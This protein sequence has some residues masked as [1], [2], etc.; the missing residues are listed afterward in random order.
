[1]GF[2]DTVFAVFGVGVL[3]FITGAAS[4]SWGLLLCSAFFVGLAIYLL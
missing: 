4:A 1:M 2:C 3:L